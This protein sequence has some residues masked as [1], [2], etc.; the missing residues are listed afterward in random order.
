MTRL[1]Q[2][3][4][5]ELLNHLQDAWEQC[6]IAQKRLEAQAAQYG[7]VACAKELLRRRRL[8]EGFDALARANRLELSLEALV[9]AG[10]YGE[11]FTDEEV[12]SC[13]STLCDAG[14][15]TWGRNR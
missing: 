3:F 4:T 15:Y 7:G 2:A 11:L 5:R 6:G 14:F 8:S 13:F 10:K 1:E 12:N 9:V